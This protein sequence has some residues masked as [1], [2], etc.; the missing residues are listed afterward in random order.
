[1]RLSGD[2]SAG[3][4]INA[5]IFSQYLEIV[6]DTGLCVNYSNFI[7]CGTVNDNL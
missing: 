1:M 6:I 7:V 4:R 3:P 2:N 5:D